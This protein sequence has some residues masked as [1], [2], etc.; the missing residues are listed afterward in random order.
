MQM[1]KP[2]DEKHPDVSNFGFVILLFVLKERNIEVNLRKINGSSLF[3][4]EQTQLVPI[5]SLSGRIL[6]SI[7]NT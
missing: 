1:F 6:I 4:Q 7:L 3:I 2:H 5:P